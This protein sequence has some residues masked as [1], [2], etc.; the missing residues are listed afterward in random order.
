TRAATESDLGS[1]LLAQLT[2]HKR[3]LQ[4]TGASVAAVAIV[5]GLPK[6]PFLIVGLFLLFLSTRVPSEAERLAREAAEE[7]E[8]GSPESGSPEEEAEW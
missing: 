7:A 6:P 8:E 2:S 4:I 1:D 3:T 5:P